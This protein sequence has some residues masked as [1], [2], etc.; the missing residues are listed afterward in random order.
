MLTC[1]LIISTS[2]FD[3]NFITLCKKLLTAVKTC[4]N[5]MNMQIHIIISRYINIYYCI[6]IRY[7]RQQM[8]LLYEFSM[9]VV[10]IYS[11][12]VSEFRCIRWCFSSMSTYF[13]STYFHGISYTIDARPITPDHC[14]VRIKIC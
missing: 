11:M 13:P 9:Q 2:E 6:C 5:I 7:L 4:R 3:L 1:V 10:I 8:R 12:T 14:I